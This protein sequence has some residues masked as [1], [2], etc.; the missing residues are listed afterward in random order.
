[1][2]TRG[3]IAV[4]GFLPRICIKLQNENIVI[5]YNIP[6]SRREYRLEPRMHPIPTPTGKFFASFFQK[7]RENP[8]PQANYQLK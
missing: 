3:S 4:H 5:G 7:R 1:M 6:N 8:H 2:E